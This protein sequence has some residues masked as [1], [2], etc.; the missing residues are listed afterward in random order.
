MLFFFS[1]RRRHTIL[2]GDWS[3]DVCSSDLLVIIRTTR[4]ACLEHMVLS[5]RCVA[6]RAFLSTF[7]VTAR[8]T[9]RRGCTAWRT[10]RGTRS[11]VKK[12][13][14]TPVV[15]AHDA[16]CSGGPA[17]MSPGH[18]PGHLALAHFVGHN[19]R[20]S[21]SDRRGSWFR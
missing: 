5:T 3:S 4:A 13:T 14:F 6:R 16:I 10:E 9:A 19:Q 8:F 12:P 1:S 7:G 21:A 20:G 15:G 11:L 2:Q 17:A 18:E